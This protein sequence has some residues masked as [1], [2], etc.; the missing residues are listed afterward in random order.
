[1]KQA[2]AMTDEALNIRV[3]ELCKWTE[4]AYHNKQSPLFARNDHFKEGYYG[5]SP[6]PKW[7]GT[8]PIPD[9]S[10]DLNAMHEAVQYLT[11][12]DGDSDFFFA[13]SAIVKADNP[14]LSI[15]SDAFLVLLVNATARQRALAFIKTKEVK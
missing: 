14:R 9:Y 5:R 1:M 8:N 10:C 15:K 11:Q 13:L 4:I 7:S 3:A 12:S 2:K 6:N